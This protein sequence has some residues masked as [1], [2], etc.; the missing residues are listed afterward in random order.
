MKKQIIIPVV[1]ALWFIFV[2]ITNFSEPIMDPSLTIAMRAAQNAGK[3]ILRGMNKLE[4]LDVKTKGRNDYVSE[5]DYQAENII[6][7][8]IKEAYPDHSFL[9]E[10]SGKEG[11]GDYQWII[12][13]LDGTTNYL[14]GFP[15]F[16]VSIAMR[17]KDVLQSSVVYNPLNDEMFLASKGDGAY[18]NQQRIRVSAQRD[19]SLSLI[20]TGFPFRNYDNLDSYMEM[21]KTILPK[22]SGIRRPGSAALDLAYVAA[23]RL[24]GFWEMDLSPWDIAAGVLLITEAGGVVSDF[25]EKDNYLVSGDIVAGNIDIHQALLEYIKP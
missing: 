14:H 18:L 1:H 21:F 8:T 11:R 10:E 3:I 16:S 15:A 12:D 19:M 13:P 24:D 9:A 2:K 4:S 17:Y 22:V 6:I 23:G 5:I 25:A 20:G 7:Q